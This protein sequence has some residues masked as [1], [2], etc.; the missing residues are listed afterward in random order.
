FAA[1]HIHEG[2][3]GIAAPVVINTGLSGSN[4]IA[5]P[6]GKGVINLVAPVSTPAAIGA[7]TR[8]LA[9]PAGFYVNIHTSK[10]GGGV[11]RAQLTN[12]L[13]V[14]LI[15]AQSTK[16]FLP[17]GSA[18]ATIGILAAGNLADLL[19]GTV[20]INGQPAT[21]VPDLSTGLITV[22]V[23]AALLANPGVLAVQIRTPAGLASKPLLIPVAAQTSVNTQAVTT[24]EAA[25]FSSTSVAPESIAAAFSTRLASAT[26]SS[27]ATP[28]PIALDATSVYVNGVLAPLF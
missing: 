24:V 6:T 1:L 9:N 7:L 8:L 20:L 19:L 5:S 14:P 25:G 23:P 4:T 21:A 3:A 22:T 16:Y 28:L 12:P 26:V 18:N 17:T 15:I 11:I 27:T 2:A 13:T 10:N